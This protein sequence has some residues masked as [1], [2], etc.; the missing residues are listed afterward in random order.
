MNRASTHRARL[1]ERRRLLALRLQ[2]QRASATFRGLAPQ[3]CGA[4]VR[5]R[6]LLPSECNIALNA[7]A[8]L[9][10]QDERL[11]YASAVAT[12]HPLRS[13][14]EFRERLREALAACTAGEQYVAVVFGPQ[15]AGLRIRA[16]DLA[17]C[18]AALERCADTFWIMPA[19]GGG[20]LI[21]VSAI[22]SELSYLT[23]A[24]T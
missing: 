22:D 3:L 7:F 10:A 11:L 4:G 17:Y 23:H 1:E 13:R 14:Q 20:W 21:E 6:K 9:P 5:F 2:R 18:A 8:H 16:R 24:P 12:H 19:S 15:E